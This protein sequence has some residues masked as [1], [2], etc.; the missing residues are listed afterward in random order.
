L[1]HELKFIFSRGFKKILI[2]G[3]DCPQLTSDH[4]LNAVQLCQS[5]QIVLGPNL[6]GGTYLIALHKEQFDPQAFSQLDWE[7]QTLI[8]SFSQYACM[9]E[10]DICQL[11]MLSDLNSP[12]QLKALLNLLDNQHSFKYWILRLIDKV[13]HIFFYFLDCTQ[14]LCTLTL[15]LTRAP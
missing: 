14:S 7:R 5:K 2:I 11:E 3:N 6:K 10:A 8:A 15:A 1:T 4:L 9:H 13:N 12:E